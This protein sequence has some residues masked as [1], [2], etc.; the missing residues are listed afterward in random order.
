MYQKL[1]LSTDITVPTGSLA[2]V[3]GARMAFD[4]EEAEMLVL[5]R[6]RGYTDAAETIDWAIK[7]DSDTAAAEGQVVGAAGQ[8]VEFSKFAMLSK[9][10]HTLEVH[11]LASGAVQLDGATLYPTLIE[12]IKFSNSAVLG[13]GENDK[14]K[15]IF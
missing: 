2:I 3:P 1:L 12:V 7:F 10:K 11:G 13:L 15:G 14:N 9:G 4:V 8:A 5:V 6:V